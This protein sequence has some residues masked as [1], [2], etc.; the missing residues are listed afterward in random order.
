MSEKIPETPP[1][2]QP[3]DK[4]LEEGSKPLV[5]QET[6][7][8][9]R[10][11][12][13][14]ARHGDVH[15]EK[16]EALL[17]R[18]SSD[19]GAKGT[20]TPKEQEEW[21]EW[22]EKLIKNGTKDNIKPKEQLFVDEIGFSDYLKTLEQVSKQY[23]L[24]PT[25]PKIAAIEAGFLLKGIVDGLNPYRLMSWVW[26]AVDKRENARWEGLESKNKP[27]ITAISIDTHGGRHQVNVPRR[28]AVYVKLQVPGPNDEPPQSV[29]NLHIEDKRILALDQLKQWSKST[30]FVGLATLPLSILTN[31]ASE[32]LGGELLRVKE[33]VNKR[34]SDSL[35]M[36]DFEFSQSRNPAAMIGVVERGK[37]AID[38]LIV[39]TYRNFLPGIAA[40]A[41]A[42]IPLLKESPLT[43]ALAVGRGLT[44]LFTGKA[45]LTEAILENQAEAKRRGAMEGR[46]M[47]IM[48][49]LELVKTDDTQAAATELA[50]Q[51]T[52][53]DKLL[54]GIGRVQTGA[55]RTRERIGNVFTYGAPIVSVGWKALM[56]RRKGMVENTQRHG[57]GLRIQ[58][59]VNPAKWKESWPD[60][61]LRG[62][63][64]VMPIWN[65]Y[66]SQE[67]TDRTVNS[68]VGLYHGTL[69]GAVRD[70]RKMEEYLGSY[71]ALDRPDGPRELV[72]TPVDKLPNLSIKLENVA[73]KNI[74]RGAT[75]EIPEG[76]FVAIQ[77]VSGEG[78]STL[79]RQMLGLYHPEGGS[80]TYGGVPVGDIK[81]FGPESLYAKIAYAPQNPY[82]FPQM[83]I[84]GNI[85]LW[86]RREV[87]DERI[88][89]TLVS[90]GMEKFVGRLDDRNL[91]F[92]GGEL[93]RLGLARALVKDPKILY[94]DEPTSNLDPQTS[95][96]VMDMIGGLRTT[97][98]AMTVV[99][100][101]HDER[102][103]Q[104]ADRVVTMKEIDNVP[105]QAEQVFVGAADATQKS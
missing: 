72:R 79:L 90:L 27:P 11:V 33:S 66:A 62:N 10:S 105:E 104:L 88:R 41:A 48:N 49:G 74:L 94:L 71:D 53:R 100:V 91:Q 21:R 19:T 26:N 54:Y 25:N 40:L 52:E 46:I 85:K 76:S 32:A 61:I 36:V 16:L 92:S 78:K 60:F 50:E 22:T 95:K 30:L 56:D 5:S 14:D 96:T 28:E 9:S 81:K 7:E 3:P 86:S 45:R 55:E 17:D 75:L 102:F 84:R 18:I 43:A 65:A 8:A 68:L 4:P 15:D 89:E 64:Y 99:A 82:Y 6:L 80:V 97:N 103:G 13:E 44:L 38:T 51:L 1:L 39:H 34:V 12:A 73:Y 69:K 98:P 24:G 58:H 31:K 29:S 70:I 57:S 47:A 35:L 67:I 20:L 77:G 101:T 2:V 63:E 83:T 37:M 87:S 42:G 23:G 93:R 59:F